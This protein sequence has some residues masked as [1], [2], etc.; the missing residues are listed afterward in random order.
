MN[1]HTLF[2]AVDHDQHHYRRMAWNPYFSKQSIYRLQGFIQA[3]VN[4]LCHRFEEH[5]ADHRPAKLIY[6]YSN[7]TA[8][9]I[10]EVCFPESYNYL[11]TASEFS[12][13]Q[14]ACWRTASETQ[15][16]FKQFPFLVPFFNSFPLWLTKITAPD[17]FT[18]IKMQLS[19]QAQANGRKTSYPVSLS[20]S[21]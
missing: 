2:D 3:T 10:S 4:N 7:V 15:H 18:I 17:V 13:E 14:H 21:L 6:A 11:T 8:D 20:V 5:K 12:P 19:L 16:L 9:I 1:E